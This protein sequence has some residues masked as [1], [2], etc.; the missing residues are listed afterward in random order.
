MLI[1]QFAPIDTP[2]AVQ[3]FLL[4]WTPQAAIFME[5]ELWPTLVLETSLKD[6]R[7][8]YSSNPTCNIVRL[9]FLEIDFLYHA[10]N[11]RD[12]RCLLKSQFGF[13]SCFFRVSESWPNYV[14]ADPLGT[15]QCTYVIKVVCAMVS[16]AYATSCCCHAISV[17][18]H[19]CTGTSLSSD[20]PYQFC[21]GSKLH[22]M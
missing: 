17:L 11:I 6:V 2:M 16:T 12:G 7:F 20:V 13:L 18:T 14:Y 22:F 15:P 10:A 8:E 1:L 21:A 3:N 5:S 4:H 19:S 9:R